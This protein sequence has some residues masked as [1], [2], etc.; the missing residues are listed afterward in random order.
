M[1]VQNLLASRTLQTMLHQPLSTMLKP[2]VS[3]G[4]SLSLDRS[5]CSASL[6]FLYR[7]R[8]LRRPWNWATPGSMPKLGSAR[9]AA[10][11]LATSRAAQYRRIRRSTALGDASDLRRISS[12]RARASSKR[13]CLARMASME[14][15]AWRPGAYP[16]CCRARAAAHRNA[17]CAAAQ[18]LR[19]RESA[20]TTSV[21]EAAAPHCSRRAP[22]RAASRWAPSA[23]ATTASTPRATS[24]GSC[25]WSG[26][27]NGSSSSPSL[28]PP[29]GSRA[30]ERR[31]AMGR[32]TGRLLG[33]GLENPGPERRTIAPARTLRNMEEERGVRTREQRSTPGKGKQNTIFLSWTPAREGESLGRFRVQPPPLLHLLARQGKQRC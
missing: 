13:R 3:N 20:A 29:A 14:W 22:A 10:I 27:E 33:G 32:R 25:C 16:G 6:T 7:Q 30:V 12:S 8:A 23:A 28:S 24:G 4:N 21:S 18:L 26:K 31:G 17:A 1:T 19:R 15:H 2:L 11:A 9:N 5:R